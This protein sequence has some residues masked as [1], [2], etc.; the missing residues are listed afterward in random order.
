MS[1]HVYVTHIFSK[2]I[3]EYQRILK[4]IKEYQRISKNI[5]EYQ[6]I[7]EYACVCNSHLFLF[8]PLTCEGMLSNI[9]LFPDVSFH[10]PK[11]K[12]TVGRI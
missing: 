9:A 2:N 10:R 12:S 4:N 7:D 6:Y 8:L 5:N 3:N 1:M 11:H